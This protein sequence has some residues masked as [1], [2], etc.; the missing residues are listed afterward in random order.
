MLALSIACKTAGPVTE[1]LGFSP[2]SELPGLDPGRWGWLRVV[3]LEQ[4]PAAETGACGKMLLVL[5]EKRAF[6]N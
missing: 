5:Q 4:S 1:S 3:R 6:I 2:I